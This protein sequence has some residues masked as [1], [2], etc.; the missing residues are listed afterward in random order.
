MYYRVAMTGRC[1]SP[2]APGILCFVLAVASVAGRQQALADP[3]PAVTPVGEVTLR[4]DQPTGEEDMLDVGLAIFD[5]GI[6][7]DPS[8][9][10]KL[11]IF[12]EIRKAEA[13]FM[14]VLL[15]QVLQA[16]NAWGVV[17][18][19]PDASLCIRNPHFLQQFHRA[20]T[21]ITARHSEIFLDAF[22]DLRTD[23]PNRVERC[24]RL[25]KNHGDVAPAPQPHFFF[26]QR[27]EVLSV[28]QDRA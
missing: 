6:P 15:R 20:C 11:G 12:P 1:R 17:R 27:Q 28:E 19:L 7:V 22:H 13:Q 14:P 26:V 5:P 18:V 16:S 8:I 4:L 3:V 24:H 25:L 9:H 21:G 23:G 2:V 10:S